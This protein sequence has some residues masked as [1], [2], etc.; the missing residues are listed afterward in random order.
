M[1]PSSHKKTMNGR[2][3][4]TLLLIYALSVASSP[5]PSPVP[6]SAPTNN[7]STVNDNDDSN[8]DDDNDDNK[9][10]DDNETSSTV[11]WTY[12]DDIITGVAILLFVL[13]LYYSTGWMWRRSRRKRNLQALEEAAV[14]R[15]TT[16]P[17]TETSA[18]LG[19]SIHVT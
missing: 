2:M 3:K 4:R 17:S 10:D 7:S 1:P 11:S 14:E 12:T 6:A 8:D 5:A 16:I 9:N 13:L 15:V 18:L 19:E